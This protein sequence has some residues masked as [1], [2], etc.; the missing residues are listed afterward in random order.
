MKERSRR[1]S[2]AVECGLQTTYII[3]IIIEIFNTSATTRSC[4]DPGT[5]VIHF[6]LPGGVRRKPQRVTSACSGGR[7]DAL[8]LPPLLLRPGAKADAGAA[9]AGAAV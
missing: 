9:A 7:H 1:Q 4:R 6:W 5:T 8:R 2:L 3:I